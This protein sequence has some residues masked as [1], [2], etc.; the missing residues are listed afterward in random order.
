MVFRMVKEPRKFLIKVSISETMSTESLM[1]KENLPILTV[2]HTRAIGSMVFDM[3]KVSRLILMAAL[4]LKEHLSM[5]YLNYLQS[6]NNSSR[7]RIAS[8]LKMRITLGSN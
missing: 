6:S 3:V 5:V 2:L 1:V 4:S 8:Q 7:D